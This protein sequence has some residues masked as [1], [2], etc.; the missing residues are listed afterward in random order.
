MQT[1]FLNVSIFYG[2]LVLI[3]C[4]DDSSDIISKDPEV[5]NI[6]VD[7]ST[8]ARGEEL[9]LE[10]EVKDGNGNLVESHITW[11]TSDPITI[12]I[13]QI[14]RI[15]GIRTGTAIITAEADGLTVIS[16]S[17]QSKLFNT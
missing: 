15:T 10:A 1:N 6:V 11:S 5:I 14:G 16:L 9:E 8:I 2:L 13:D 12:D 17:S 4:N 7:K 3:S